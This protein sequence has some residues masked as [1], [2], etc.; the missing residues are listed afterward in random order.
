VTGPYWL[1]VAGG[2]L[3]V[4]VVV[5]MV[6]RRFLRGPYAAIWV[7]LGSVSIVLALFPGV[8]AWA[9]HMTGVE[10]PFNLLLFLGCIAMLMMIM[11][12]SAETGRLLQRTRALA[13]EIA[14]LRAAAERTANPQA[15]AAA[16]GP[17]NTQHAEKAAVR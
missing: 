10:V 4:A 13:E 7:L 3:V 6:R 1:G 17:D 5:E 16:S 8:V 9:A 12:L 11:Q 15:G 14:L 2:L